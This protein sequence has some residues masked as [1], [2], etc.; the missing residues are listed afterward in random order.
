MASAKKRQDPASQEHGTGPARVVAVPRL[1]FVALA[2]LVVAPWLV[3]AALY[4]TGRGNELADAVSVG[5]TEEVPRGPWGQL[6]T[7]TIVIS[8]PLELVSTDLGPVSGP[9]WALP[10]VSAEEFEAYLVSSGVAPA[11]ARAVRPS[12]RPEPR[13]GG[14]VAFP[15]PDFVKRLAPDVRANLYGALARSPLNEAQAHAYRYNGGARVEEWF[16]GSLI[17]PATRQLV[18]PLVYRLDGYL[19]FADLDLIRT[20][21]ADEAELRRLAKTLLRQSTVLVQLT[22]PDRAAVPGL[23]DYWGRGG[24]RTDLRPLLESIAGGGNDRQIDITHLLPAFARDHLYRYPKLSAA[25]FDKPVI[26]NCLWTSLNFFSAEPD[27][28]FLD[29][30]VA[31]STLKGDYF[32]VENGFQL[33]DVIAFLDEEGDIFHVVVYLADDLVLTKNGTSPMAPWIILALDEVKNYYSTRSRAMRLIAHR[34]NDL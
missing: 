32:V 19:Y 24:R 4:L 9:H 28:K 26:A 34:R 11:D 33:G 12:V 18:E 23:V 16:N 1:W 25:D 15:D 3:I 22:V 13:I 7:T 17:S 6:R 5:P 27:D 2:A 10:G 14:V 20:Q 21:I 31:L 8:P 30:D 29:V